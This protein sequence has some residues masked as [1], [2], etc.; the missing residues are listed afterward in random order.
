MSSYP[1]LPTRPTQAQLPGIIAPLPAVVGDV[2]PLA[3]GNVA[4]T[5]DGR[6]IGQWADEHSAREGLATFQRMGLCV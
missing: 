4:V 3:N 5:L 1:T 6:V 2:L